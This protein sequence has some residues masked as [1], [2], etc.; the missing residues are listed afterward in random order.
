M[1]LFKV[2]LYDLR[3]NSVQFILRILFAV[4]LFSYICF[5]FI[6]D[7]FHFF[8]DV[9]SHPVKIGELG[10]SFG[11]LILFELGG[12]VPL[13]NNTNISNLSFPTIFFVVHI[14]LLFFTLNYVHTDLNRGGIQVFTRLGSFRT[15]WFSKFFWNIL[16]VLAYYTIGF[17][18]IWVLFHLL[19]SN[20]SL[21]P[22]AEAFIR[23]FH[24]IYIVVS[25]K[26]LF[27][28]YFVMPV[29][30]MLSLSL[31][32]MTLTLFIKPIY[33]FIITSLYFAAGIFFI[34][35]LFVSNYAMPVR[36]SAVDLY[37]FDV[38]SGLIICFAIITLSYITGLFRASRM[39]ILGER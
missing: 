3:S 24:A 19:G 8:A 36:S 37:N 2:L 30:V 18:T 15:W 31:A 21:Q 9:V 1:K 32:Q 20:T 16:T 28:A 39:D 22:S 33:S 27:V 13:L 7:A 11:D 4:I 5:L 34:Y 17:A 29:M 10:L 23:K 6:F 25:S 14:T 26:E 35:P 12:N 38:L